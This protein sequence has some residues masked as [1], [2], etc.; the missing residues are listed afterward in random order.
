MNETVVVM[1]RENSL[2]KLWQRND[3]F[4]RMGAHV[5]ALGGVQVVRRPEENYEGRHRAL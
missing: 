4:H 5:L 3:A 2:M 1:G